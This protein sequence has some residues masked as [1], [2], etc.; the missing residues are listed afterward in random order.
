M[1]AIDFVAVFSGNWLYYE[2][3]KNP[4]LETEAQFS[5]EQNASVMN[6]NIAFQWGSLACHSL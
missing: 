3:R 5:V 1:R 4:P 2:N 6:T